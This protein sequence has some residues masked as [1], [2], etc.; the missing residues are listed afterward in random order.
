VEIEEVKILIALAISEKHAENVAR[1]T[2]IE[3]RII[4]IDGNGTGRIGALQRQDI[5]LAEIATNQS[6]MN[7]KIDKALHS[8]TS[9]DKKSVINVL[10]QGFGSILV[11]LGLII[12]YI[13]YRDAHHP[14]DH[15][16]EHT[17]PQNSIV[18]EN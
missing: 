16:A 3:E 10:Y 14:K 5:K 1:L 17:T 13:T 7:S 2:K 18:G 12:G 4:G 15:I 8:A 6:V 11:I 9:W